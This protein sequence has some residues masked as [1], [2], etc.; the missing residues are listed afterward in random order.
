M[1]GS[2]VDSRHVCLPAELRLPVS[3]RQVQPEVRYATPLWSFKDFQGEN[4]IKLVSDGEC[5]YVFI[6][7]KKRTAL[8]EKLKYIFFSPMF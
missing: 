5:V 1:D 3:R 6:N 8:S 4:T 7:Q 2:R